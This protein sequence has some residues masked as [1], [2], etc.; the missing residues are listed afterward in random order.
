MSFLRTGAMSCGSGEQALLMA[1]CAQM[2]GFYDIPGA[3]A[4]GMSDSKLPDAQSGAEKGYTLALAAQAGASMIIESAGM[5]ASLMG[6]AFEGY[7]I[8]NDI[9]GAVQ[10]TVRGVEVNDETLSFDVI[11]DTVYGEGHFLTRRQTIERMKCDYLYPEVSDRSNLADWADRGATDIWHRA[12]V[13]TREILA[14]H[15]PA[16]I[17]PKIDARIRDKFNILLPCHTMDPDY[18]R[19]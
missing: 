17:D 1:G 5:Q 11:R 14:K 15:Y 16:H 12:K 4:A 9:L 7:V 10:R 6:T 3:V 13:R 18:G 8:D 19:W 2:A